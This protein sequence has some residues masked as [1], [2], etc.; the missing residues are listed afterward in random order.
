VVTNYKGA[1]KMSLTVSSKTALIRLQYKAERRLVDNMVA[2]VIKN[3]PTHKLNIKPVKVSGKVYTRKL[4]AQELAK[5]QATAKQQRKIAKMPV[6][7][8][9]FNGLPSYLVSGNNRST[10]A[11]DKPTI[12]VKKYSTKGKWSTIPV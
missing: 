6:F 10:G 2:R 1:N 11:S 8:K 12:G 9:S 7:N 5:L 3:H 4:T